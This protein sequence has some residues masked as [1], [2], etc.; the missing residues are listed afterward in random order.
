VSLPFA[1][2]VVVWS[3]DRP[4]HDVYR[5]GERFVLGRDIV[6]R[7]DDR[8]SRQHTAFS[9]VDSR[10]QIADCNSRNGTYLERQLLHVDGLRPGLPAIVRSGHTITI[11]IADVRPYEHVPITRRGSLVV[12]GSLDKQVRAVD[13]AAVAED[14]V[15]IFGALSIGRALAV[16]Y[17]TKLGG[18]H[19]LIDTATTQI[20][21]ALD[22]AAP[23]RTI[24]VIVTG[25]IGAADWQALAPWLET[26]VRF[27]FV[28]R[29]ETQAIGMPTALAQRLAGTIVSIPRFRFDELPTTL[30]EM[31]RARF[32]EGHLHV[33]AV[34]AAL[35]RARTIDEDQ[36][37]GSFR[38]GL[39]RWDR[40]GAFRD[41][42]FS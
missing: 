39:D 16:G 7:S 27:A 42:N 22:R 5:I 38:A 29:H 41:A 26:D 15:M 2:I 23:M 18:T 35:V 24:I 8:I 21:R 9:V 14:N 10:I 19:L 11:A 30:H 40:Q 34:E 31:F 25:P 12:A 37:L 32:A 13:L 20:A 33:S 6:D 4:R 17:A 36:L 3:G 1:G 28:M